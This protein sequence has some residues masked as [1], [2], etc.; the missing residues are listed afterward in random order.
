M[1]EHYRI[2]N[3]TLAIL[4]HDGQK[5]PITIPRGGEIEVI[6]GPLDGTQLMRVSWEGNT[7]LMFTTDI[8]ERGE[9]I[10]AAGQ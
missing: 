7:V 3:P 2:K 4:D 5:I 10:S 8:R 1:R 9:R 6:D